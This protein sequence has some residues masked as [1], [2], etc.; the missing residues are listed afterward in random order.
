MVDAKLFRQQYIDKIMNTPLTAK[1]RERML[2]GVDEAVRK[3]EQELKKDK[4]KERWFATKKR[5]K[6]TF[7]ASN[8]EV[9]NI[10]IVLKKY[11]SYDN[12]AFFNRQLDLLT[13]VYGVLS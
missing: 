9:L 11:T 7:G 1:D 12:E 2:G 5:I 13:E 4:E 3:Y 10:I 8:E 6:E